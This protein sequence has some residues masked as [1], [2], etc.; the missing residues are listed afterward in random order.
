MVF[1]TGL[2]GAEKVR[3]FEFFV[4]FLM[5]VLICLETKNWT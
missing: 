1:S 3:F 2:F 4:C 5:F